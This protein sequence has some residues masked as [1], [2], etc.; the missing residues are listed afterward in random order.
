MREKAAA[1][2]RK[3]EMSS[4]M[5]VVSEQPDEEPDPM[6]ATIKRFGGFSR[7]DPLAAT[8]KQGAPIRAVVQSPMDTY[9]ISD[10]EDS[11]TDESDDSDDE[12]EK[13]KKKVCWNLEL[14]SLVQCVR[15]KANFCCPSRHFFKFQIPT[16]AKRENL[17]PALEKQYTGGAKGKLCDPDEIFPEVQTCDLEA[18][19]EKKK[20]R[21]TRRTSS[22]NWTKDRVTV[23]EKLVYK[24]TM[25]F[26]REGAESQRNRTK[27]RTIL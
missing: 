21:Y 13:Q 17:L 15:R 18:I 23:E 25:G 14:E 10:R 22:G 5:A 12:N 4:T 7:P 9:E 1:A 16:W 11:D 26:A 19:F 20:G 3:Q 2:Y 27:Q 8:I 6:D 24:R